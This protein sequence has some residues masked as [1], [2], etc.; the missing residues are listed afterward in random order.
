MHCGGAYSDMRGIRP[1]RSERPPGPVYI[2]DIVADTEP[3]EDD[4]EVVVIYYGPT[5]PIEK[6]SGVSLFACQQRRSKGLYRLQGYTIST[7]ERFLRG[8]FLRSAA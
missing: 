1:I 5:V 2:T 8:V 7:W 4:D 3:I 6:S